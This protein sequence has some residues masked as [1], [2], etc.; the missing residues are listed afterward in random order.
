MP[1]DLQWL[2]REGAGPW[3]QT[4]QLLGQQLAQSIVARFH[5]IRFR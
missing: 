2:A 3:R 1:L 5:G 4:L